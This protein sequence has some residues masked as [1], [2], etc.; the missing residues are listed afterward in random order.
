MRGSV[1]RQAGAV[2]GFVCPKLSPAIVQVV[3]LG[4]AAMLDDPVLT[5][6][7]HPV[8][9]A[10]DVCFDPRRPVGVHLL[11]EDIVLWQ[12]DDRVLAWQDLCVHRGT[13]LSL[14]RI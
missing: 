11:G 9:L 14:G 1:T 5:D 13:R 2:D 10:R 3:L 6:D 8:A 4:C 12:V 7:W